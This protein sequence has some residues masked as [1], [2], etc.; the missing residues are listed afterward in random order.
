MMKVVTVLFTLLVSSASFAQGINNPQTNASQLTTGTLAAARGGAGTINGALKGNGSGVVSQAA[1]ADLSNGTTNC[2]A[3]VGQLPGT[4]TNDDAAAGKVGEIIS[5]TVLPGAPVSLTTN[6]TANLA[7][8]SLT[9]G[10]WDVYAECDFQGAGGTTAVNIWQCSVSTT[11]GTI[12]LNPGRFATQFPSTLFSPY[13]A[14][15]AVGLTAGPVRASLS[16][17]TTYYCTANSQF[18]VNTQ[19]VYG[20]CRARRIR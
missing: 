17:T 19:T 6:T 16:G 3:A 14:V 2:S 5:S 12:D 7:S 11:T 10:D 9:A 8:L 15:S 1:C 13:A 20:V 4:A 18:S